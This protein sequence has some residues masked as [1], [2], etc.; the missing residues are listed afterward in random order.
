MQVAGN[1]LVNGATVG[2]VE[3][4]GKMGRTNMASSRD[5]DTDRDE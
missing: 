1:S 4:R 5:R 3:F 2:A